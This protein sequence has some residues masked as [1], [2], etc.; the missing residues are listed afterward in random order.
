MGAQTAF[1]KVKANHEQQLIRKYNVLVE[2]P[3]HDFGHAGYTG[4]IAESAGLTI[5]QLEFEDKESAIDY[6]FENTS[7]WGN[8]VAVKLRGTNTWI[9]GGT[10]SD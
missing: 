8:S 3:L 5:S 1:Y 2:E 6:L 7:K 10:Y 9:I 4:T